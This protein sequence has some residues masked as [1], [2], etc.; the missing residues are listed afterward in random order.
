MPQQKTKIM[1]KMKIQLIATTALF[2]LALFSCSKDEEIIT[3]NTDP[4][5]AKMVA[6][7]TKSYDDVVTM[8][9][10]ATIQYMED[11][12]YTEYAFG[13][14]VTVLYDSINT[15]LIFDLGTEGC[16]GLDGR[17]RKGKIIVDYN[18]IPRE[19][20]STLLITLDNFSVD[21][22]QIN[23]TLT[24][25]TIDYNNNGQLEMSYAVTDG[26]Y[27]EPHGDIITLE[28]NRTVTWTSGAGSENLYDDVF[29]TTGGFSGSV[30]GYNYSGVIAEAVVFN[31]ACWAEGI[32]YPISGE[33][34]LT[35]PDNINRAI[36]YGDGDCDKEI[37][38]TI[39]LKTYT[40]LLP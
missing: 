32:Y 20:G 30:D 18:G 37:A 3:E 27:T 11:P 39:G 19:P 38:I 31:S 36:N 1:K 14:C 25:N 16:I 24:Y 9:E 33:I 28:C 34:Q 8:S 6:E 10:E 35:F 15:V 13:N 21:G 12:N 4:G 29:E 40:Y 7:T 17:E 22:Y 2:T 23:G 5:S 26:I